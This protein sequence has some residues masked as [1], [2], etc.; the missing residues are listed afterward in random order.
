MIQ[1][2]SNKIEKWIEEIIQSVWGKEPFEEI[3]WNQK[4]IPKLLIK[5][6]KF[7]K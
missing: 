6:L 2:I 7:Q 4:G 5:L 3:N 1:R